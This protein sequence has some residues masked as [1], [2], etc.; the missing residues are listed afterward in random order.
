MNIYMVASFTVQSS[1]RGHPAIQVY[2][3]Q[4]FHYSSQQLFSRHSAYSCNIQGKL[5]APISATSLPPISSYADNMTGQGLSELPD[6][7]LR[8]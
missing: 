8:P 7:S 2:V 4:M 6:K 5:V 1:Y 3:Y